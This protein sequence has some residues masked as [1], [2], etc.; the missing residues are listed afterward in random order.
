MVMFNFEK[1]DAKKSKAGNKTNKHISNGL[2][3]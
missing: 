1:A 2:E 3:F